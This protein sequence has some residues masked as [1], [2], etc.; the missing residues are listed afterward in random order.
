MFTDDS[1][2]FS[3]SVP[4]NWQVEM[5]LDLLSLQNPTIGVATLFYAIDESSGNNVMVVA[6]LRELLEFERQPIDI[7]QY[8]ESQ[9]DDLQESVGK[10]TPINKTSV[11][12]DGIE[13]IQLRMNKSGIELIMNILISNEPRMLCGSMPLI[14]QGTSSSEDRPIIERALDSFT[15]LPTAAAGVNCDDRKYLSLVDTPKTDFDDT[16]SAG[17]LINEFLDDSVKAS[18]KYDLQ[19]LS[20]SGLVNDVNHD[21]VFSTLYVTILDSDVVDSLPKTMTGV[22]CMI[23]NPKEVEALGVNTPYLRGVTDFGDETNILLQCRLHSSAS[24]LVRI[25]ECAAGFVNCSAIN[26]IDSTF[27][28][29]K[30][31]TSGDLQLVVN[32]E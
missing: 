19:T 18:E 32:D 4:S 22:Q 12:V 13:T 25:L 2:S 31:N 29:A 8:V 28:L 7:N 23:S 20:V 9:I 1:D 27:L 26:A 15:V 24:P 5:D 21:L 17:S 30:L 10:T 16:I 3:I 6:D 11:V 14:V